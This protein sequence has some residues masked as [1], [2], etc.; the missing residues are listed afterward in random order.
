MCDA[1][2]ASRC[3]EG[4]LTC[5]FWPS[6]RMNSSSDRSTKCCLPSFEVEF[7]VESRPLARR[8]HDAEI[9]ILQPAIPGASTPTSKPTSPRIP[10]S[11]SKT[12]DD[13]ASRKSS[14]PSA[15]P[16]ARSSTCSTQASGRPTA[17]PKTRRRTTARSTHL[18][19]SELL[20]PT[21]VTEL[22]R[23][24][25][26]AR[27]QQYQRYFADADQRPDPPPQRSRPGRAGQRPGAAQ[28]AAADQDDRDHRRD[29]GC[30]AAG[31]PADGEHARH[32]GRADHAGVVRGVRPG[33]DGRRA[34]A[35]L[36]R[37]ARSRRPGR[38]T[39]TRSNRATARSS[40]T[41]APTTARPR[42]F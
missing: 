36:R 30:D 11:S 37:P 29:A 21:L 15:M 17:A 38:S 7:L 25:T 31:E 42:P 10:A 41:S 19:L 35:L 24:M 23:S 3:G 5:A 1:W 2:L 39:I 4:R 26:R 8:L 16:A 33:R 20:R 12:T 22:S 6:V 40:R 27:V 14:R 18:E 34:A 28:P 32:P 9:A 13:A